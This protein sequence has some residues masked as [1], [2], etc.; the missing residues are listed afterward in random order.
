[1]KIGQISLS[2]LGQEPTFKRFVVSF[3]NSSQNLGPVCMSDGH[4]TCRLV[5][6]YT[7]ATAQC[8]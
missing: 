7:V 2:L 8:I 1:M 5:T 6:E 3:Q 4:K